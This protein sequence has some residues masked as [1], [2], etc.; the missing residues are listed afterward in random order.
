MGMWINEDNKMD[1][2]RIYLKRCYVVY[3]VHTSIQFHILHSI[4][5]AHPNPITLVFVLD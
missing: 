2:M 1:K 5:R 3:L 4:P